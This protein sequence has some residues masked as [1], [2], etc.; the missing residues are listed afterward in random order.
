MSETWAESMHTVEIIDPSAVLS[1]T[2][3]PPLWQQ[4]QEGIETHEKQ[5]QKKGERKQ[6]TV[7]TDLNLKYY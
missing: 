5:L 7:I 4:Q 2:L 6:H 1:I 3:N